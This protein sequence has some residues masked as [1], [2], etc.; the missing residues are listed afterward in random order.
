MYNWLG[1]VKSISVTEIWEGNM[2]KLSEV[3][4]NKRNALTTCN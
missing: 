3:I 4:R 2:E 1:F